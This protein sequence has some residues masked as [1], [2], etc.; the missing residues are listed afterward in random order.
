MLPLWGSPGGP[1]CLR[2]LASSFPCGSEFLHF[3]DLAHHPGDSLSHLVQIFC[4]EAKPSGLCG[5]NCSHSC[6]QDPWVP[7]NN[8][9]FPP[10]KDHM[11]RVASLYS[12]LTNLN[13]PNPSPCAWPHLINRAEPQTF[14]DSQNPGLK[15]FPSRTGK[16]F[17]ASNCSRLLYI[18][19]EKQLVK[20]QPLSL[21][22]LPCFFVILKAKLIHNDKA[23][24]LE[25]FLGGRK[26]SWQM[27]KMWLVDK[28]GH[29]AV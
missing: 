6:P 22:S 2:V 12:T 27:S 25:W 23:L 4:G 20:L 9:H 24:F 8:C 7:G 29:M 13:K 1:Q 18:A 11:N 19:R 26:R 17:R 15:R 10:R 3:F 21:L 16:V 5:E 14:P 28:I